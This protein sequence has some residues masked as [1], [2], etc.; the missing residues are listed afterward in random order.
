MSFTCYSVSVCV[1]V[2]VIQFF[3]FFYFLTYLFIYFCLFTLISASF[4]F[5]FLVWFFLCLHFAHRTFFADVF[6]SL[7]AIFFIISFATV[8]CCAV[9]CYTSPICSLS[10]CLLS[11]SFQLFICLLLGCLFCLSNDKCILRANI[12]KN[13]ITYTVVYRALY[14]HTNTHREKIRQKNSMW[15]ELDGPV[16]I[17]VEPYYAESLGI[18]NFSSSF[19]LRGAGCWF[20]L[21]YSFCFFFLSFRSDFFS[22]SLPLALCVC[23][24]FCVY[25]STPA[26]IFPPHLRILSFFPCE[27]CKWVS[28]CVWARVQ[29]KLKCFFRCFMPNVSRL[30]T[31]TR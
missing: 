5:Y 31:S 21:L 8:L 20:L 13:T 11:S 27:W 1:C 15:F 26:H 3:V 29:H 19:S 30:I 18:S 14:P 22:L 24:S 7:S 2:C 12:G 6:F 28:L 9:C 10:I 23:G 4:L 16:H 17:I 25:S